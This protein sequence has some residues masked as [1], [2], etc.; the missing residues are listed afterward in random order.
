MN[1]R[2]RYIAALLVALAALGASRAYAGSPLTEAQRW[3]AMH[4][5]FVACRDTRGATA[6]HTCAARYAE[7]SLELYPTQKPSKQK[8][9]RK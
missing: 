9:P 5:A 1:A 2:P 8:E 4:A 7:L 3:E 6:Q